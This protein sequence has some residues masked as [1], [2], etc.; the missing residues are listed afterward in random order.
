MPSAFEESTDPIFI[1]DLPSLAVIDANRA[2]YRTLGYTT[3]EVRGKRL[4]DLLDGPAL[5]AIV[6]RCAPAQ[7][8]KHGTPF[9]A[10]TVGLMKKDRS[11]VMLRIACHVAQHGDQQVLYVQG[12]PPKA[13]LEKAEG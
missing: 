4:G 12:R 13:D 5:Q 9:S 10:G 11:L 7:D 3:E 8:R 6:S 2:A 1:V